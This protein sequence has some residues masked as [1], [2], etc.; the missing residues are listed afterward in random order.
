MNPSN[1]IKTAEL[2]DTLLPRKYTKAALTL[3]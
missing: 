1:A 3:D 2:E